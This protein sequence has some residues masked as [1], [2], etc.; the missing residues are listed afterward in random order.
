MIKDFFHQINDLSKHHY[1]NSTSY[2]KIVDMLFNEIKI[3]ELKDI[4]YLPVNLFKH[5]DLKSISD[6]DV[7]KI[8]KSSGT[9]SGVPSRIFL[10]KKNARKQ[11]EVLNL[12]LGRL[13]GKK[14]FPMIIVGKKNSISNNKS[15]DA[16]TAAVLGF[17]LFA[18][19]IFYLNENNEINYEGLNK[20]IKKNLNEKFILFGFTFDIY[21]ILINDFKLKNLKFD[22]NTNS[23]IIHGGGWKK[24]E[25][26]KISKKELNYLLKSK[27]R[28][29]NIINYYGLIEQTGSIF[30]DCKEC[31][32]FV[33]SEYS[34]VII[35]DNNFNVLRP[36]QK[37]FVQ[38]LST[39]P[40]SYPGH[41]ILTEDIGEIVENN[42]QCKKIGK[43]FLIHGRSIKSEIRGCSD[44]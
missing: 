22:L 1:K 3:K 11:S 6:R 13:I 29:E 30:F 35:R 12:L 24:L 18:K 7:F 20:F 5:N 19:E 25:N 15:F 4:P 34:N 44:A 31:G 39:L 38:L 26:K 10:D 2:K 37:G 21:Q 16:K 33:T 28:I 32:S 17:S 14:R 9:T 41:S 23:I 42:C 43:R 27:F 40:T 8:L 36:N